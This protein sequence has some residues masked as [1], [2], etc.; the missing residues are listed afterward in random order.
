[1]AAIRGTGQEPINSEYYT[2]HDWNKK[3]QLL[4]GEGNFA[5]CYQWSKMR[6]EQRAW[7][8]IEFFQPEIEM[9]SICPSMIF[10]P[11][12]DKS[13]LGYSCKLVEQWI[14]G[15]RKTESRLFVDVRD[16]ALAHYHAAISPYSYNKRYIVSHERRLHAN[17]IMQLL[18]NTAL[19]CGMAVGDMFFDDN[20]NGGFTKVGDKEV[21]S[22]ERME[23]DLQV[24]LRPP[25]QTLID[26][27][28]SMSNLQQYL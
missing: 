11:I 24:S 3:S 22:L 18:K 7:E 2:H 12:R 1:M 28:K 21:E 10:G 13:Q 19:E 15:T 8:I 5:N 9:V 23:R 20:F 14:R 27:I 4:E 16:L 26:M 25:E 6:S 17:K